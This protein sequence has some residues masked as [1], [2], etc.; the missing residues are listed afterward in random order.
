LNDDY[1][2]ALEYRAEAYLALGRLKEARADYAWGVAKDDRAARTFLQAAATW[3]SD[4]RADGRKRVKWAD[5]AAFAAWVQEEQ[6]RLGP[7]EA[8][9]W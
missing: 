3:I 8:R 9:P 7:G 2:E 6:E 5:A 1:V 4:A